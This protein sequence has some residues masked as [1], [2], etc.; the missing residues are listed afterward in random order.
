MRF[1]SV[2][3]ASQV[4]QELKR[5]SDRVLMTE[6]GQLQQRVGEMVGGDLQRIMYCIDLIEASFPK[7]YTFRLGW[8]Y[9]LGSS[10]I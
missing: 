10:Q 8:R 3:E 9:I 2:S 6:G 7:R 5:V 4:V 1:C